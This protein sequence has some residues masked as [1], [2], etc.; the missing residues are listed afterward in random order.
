MDRLIP[1]QETDGDLFLETLSR[2][3]QPSKTFKMHIYDKKLHGFITS[4]KEALEQMIYKY[5]NTEKGDFYIY[6]TFG[7]K[8]KDIFYKPKTFAYHTLCGRIK[9]DLE[10]DDRIKEVDKFIFYKEKSKKHDLA[11]GFTVHSIYGDLAYE[12][13]VNLG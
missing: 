8:K 3:I 11:M 6:P 5:V 7:L 9:E 2:E 1:K 4:E 12:G 10:W 13:V